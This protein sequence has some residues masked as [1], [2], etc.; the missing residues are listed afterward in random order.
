[1]GR[2]CEGGL[3]RKSIAGLARSYG[4]MGDSPIPGG[5]ATA[6][7][8]G[9]HSYPARG[10]HRLRRHRHSLAGHIY[11]VTATARDRRPW[12]TARAA[13]AAVRCFGTPTLWGDAEPLAWVLMPDH[14]HWL[15]RLG[16]RDNLSGVVNRLKSGSARAVNATLQRTGSVWAPAFHEHTMRDET[17]IRAAAAYIRHNPVR[18][19]LVAAAED[20]PYL[21]PPPAS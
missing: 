2:S 19:G 12:F 11:L 16:D 8:C 7:P 18:A 4:V 17:H 20:Y 14:A 1:M 5:R 13:T 3:E 10:Q 6:P 9:M 15:I 21:Y